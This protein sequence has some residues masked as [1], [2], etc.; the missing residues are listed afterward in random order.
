[1]LP[2]RRRPLGLSIGV[3]AALL[4]SMVLVGPTVASSSSTTLTNGASLE[5]SLDSPVAD[6]DYLVGDTVTASGTASLGLG[7]PDATIVY[8]IDQSG[9]TALPGGACGSVLQCEQTFVVGIN[10]A[11]AAAGSVKNVGLGSFDSNAYARFGLGDPTDPAFDTAVNA[12]VPGSNTNFAAALAVAVDYFQQPT[13]GTHKFLIFLSDGIENL[14]GDG[15]ASLAAL[16]SMGVVSNSFAVGS[17]SSCTGGA[18]ISLADIALGGGTCT[19]VTD[20]NTLP[21]LIPN[22]VGSVLDKVEVSVDGGTGTVVPTSPATPAD[23]PVSVTYSLAIPGLAA[24][25]HEICATATGHDV[26]SDTPT[27][28]TAC[29]TVHVLGISLAPP[30][31]TNELG[32]PGQTHTV[33]ATIAAGTTVGGRTVSFSVISGPNAGQNGTA[34]TDSSGNADFTYP[35]TQGTAGIGTDTIQ[36]CFSIV[37]ANGAPETACATALKVWQDTTP[38]SASCTETTNPAGKNVPKSGP[39]AGKSGQNPDGFYLL[40]GTDAVGVASIVVADDGSAFVSDPFAT[41]DKVKITQAPG[42]TPNDRRPGPGVITSHLTLKG[43]AILRVTDTSGNVTEVS[44]KVA[45]PP[46]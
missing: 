19:V 5:I 37:S 11:A 31:A 40:T 29:E 34:D 26:F 10:D 33:T 23:G 41:G 14:G 36:A 44:C 15:A 30:T 35:A 12:L 18:D 4:A 27:S 39:N 42:A 17:G 16:D 28:T 32:T 3:L 21:D 38:P 20:P 2:N 6:T 1:M 25:D 13:A 24:G 45:P 7:T 9:S 22:L 8:M 46:K 43:D